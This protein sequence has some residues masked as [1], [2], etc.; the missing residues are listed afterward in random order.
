LTYRAAA[1]V[2]TID[3]PSGAGKG[4][5]SR[6]LAARLGWR[7]LDSG[8]L[9]RLTALAGQRGGLLPDDRAGHANIAQRMAVNFTV[10]ADGGEGI[11]LGDEEV[12]L[13]L[14]TE[15]TGAGASRVALWP[16]VR[17]ALLQRQRDFAQTPGL[18]AD[19]RDMGTVVFPLAELKIFLSAS[20]AERAQRRYKQLKDKGVAV[21]LAA[22]SLE[23]A[24][25]DRQD[26][27]RP[28]SP[29]VPAADALTI[30]STDLSIQAVV[31]AIS[32]A[33]ADRGLW[34]RERV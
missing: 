12:S 23:I 5:V 30:D 24:E 15:R 8:A 31:A 16:E 21:N 29:M 34:P 10:L 11:L 22:L 7:L 33:G 3:G 17:Q 13:E 1:P 19:G 4:A 27:L 18:V 32:A 2:V 14:R 25:R 20:A 6:A 26:S 28:V 9:Y